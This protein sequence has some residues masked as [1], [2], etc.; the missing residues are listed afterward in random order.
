MKKNNAIKLWK[1]LREKTI[2]ISEYLKS[3]FPNEINLLQFLEQLEDKHD[4]LHA[5]IK[6][7]NARDLPDFFNKRTTSEKVEDIEGTMGYL[8]QAVET[9]EEILIENDL[10]NRCSEC[11]DL[12]NCCN[13]I[14]EPPDKKDD[15]YLN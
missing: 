14:S 12:G 5:T 3:T 15:E 13:E 8:L 9:V 11:G 10:A 6:T 4:I 1:E 7:E 2:E